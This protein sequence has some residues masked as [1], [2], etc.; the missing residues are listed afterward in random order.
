MRLLFLL[1]LPCL[2]GCTASPDASLRPA[3]YSWQT[4]LQA[5]PAT[6]KYLDT[7]NSSTLYVKI[8][9]IGRDP[10]TRQIQPYATLRT[11]DTSA[12]S[13]LQF[14]PTVFITNEVFQHSTPEERTALVAQLATALRPWCVSQPATEVQLDCDWSGSTREA[15]FSFLREMKTA[16]PPATPLSATVRLHQYKF[17]QKTGVPPVDRGMLMLYNT[18]DIDRP[19]LRNSIFNAEDARQYVQGAPARYPLP[20]DV[21]LPLFSWTLVFRDDVLW[22]IIPELQ[23]E[24]LLDSVRFTMQV[25]DYPHTLPLW[26]VRRGTFIAG[27]YLRPDDLLRHECISPDVLRQAARLATRLHLAPDA[28]VAFFHLDTLTMRRYPATLLRGVWQGMETER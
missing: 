1:S 20:L 18:G 19:V 23:Q 16:L 7:L 3:F 12:L 8:M 26:R 13:G 11:G 2:L 17:P 25:T 24:E 14:I 5:S 15:Y 21:A 28:R 9:D 6:R 10:L 4:T 27:H 22:K